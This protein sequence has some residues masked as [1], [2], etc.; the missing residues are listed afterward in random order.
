MFHFFAPLAFRYLLAC[1]QRL[2]QNLARVSLAVNT[3]PQWAQV[4]ARDG[5]MAERRAPGVVM[6]FSFVVDHPHNRFGTIRMVA[7]VEEFERDSGC[8]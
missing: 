3:A 8:L 1:L 5:R 2:L 4:T 7:S 6:L